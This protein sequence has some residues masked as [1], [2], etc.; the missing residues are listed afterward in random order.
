MPNAERIR[1]QRQNSFTKALSREL[2]EH[3]ILVNCVAPGAIDT[4]MIRGL[5]AE[6]VSAMIADSKKKRLGTAG[7]V[8]QLVAWL[9]TDASR[10][11]TGTVFDVSGGR[12][13]Y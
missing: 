3:N 2:A 6:V 7:E 11:N 12:A 13:R 5:G 9:A 4:D 10:F 8:A 1:T